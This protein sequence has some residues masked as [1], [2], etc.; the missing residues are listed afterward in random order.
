MEPQNQQFP[1]YLVRLEN[2]RD[3][4]IRV[5]CVP[6]VG[7]ES[8][9]TV[10]YPL[11]VNQAEC[12]VEPLQPEDI[13]YSLNDLSAVLMKQSRGR[14]V[15][16]GVSFSPV[17]S[18]PLTYRVIENWFRND[19]HAQITNLDYDKI[20]HALEIVKPLAASEPEPP[21]PQQ[22]PGMQQRPG[23]V[24]VNNRGSGNSKGDKH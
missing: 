18:Q 3:N 16:M 6:I 10:R 17:M 13:E 8:D 11:V 15:V 12:F 7:W 22:P 21:P 14:S 20:E 1:L 2:C 9:G 19:I 23:P 5:R 4:Q 24:P